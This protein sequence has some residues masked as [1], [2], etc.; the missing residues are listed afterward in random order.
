MRAQEYFIGGLA[1][2]EPGDTVRVEFGPKMR[3]EQ[4]LSVS[5][6]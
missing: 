1:T 5:L 3:R 6:R 4:V 2:V